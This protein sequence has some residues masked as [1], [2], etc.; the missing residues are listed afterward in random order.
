VERMLD[1]CAEGGRVAITVPDGAR[2]AFEGHENFWSDDD[3]RDFLAPHGLESITRIDE[4]R[5]LF[6][7]LAPG[8]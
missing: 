5:T 1:W 3:L 4:G 7:V 2:Y 6:A 8:Q